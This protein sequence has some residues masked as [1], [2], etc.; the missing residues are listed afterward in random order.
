V[1]HAAVSRD[2]NLRVI[3]CLTFDRRAAPQEIAAGKAA[4]IACRSVLHSVELSGTFD[5]MFEAEIAD[6]AAYNAQLNLCAEPM[7]R[8]V[9]RYE[10]NFVC[11]RFVRREKADRAIWVPHNNG[12]KRIDCAAI[13]KV[14]A[15][16]DYMRVHS[17]R[18]SWML[19]ST[20]G[21]LKERLGCED[22]IQLNRSLIVRCGF[23]GEVVHSGRQWTAVLNDGTRERIAKGGVPAMFEMLNTDST[24]AKRRLSTLEATVEA[25]ATS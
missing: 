8:L 4:I 10:A 17:A 6:M 16:G 3:M 18:Q 21:A 9:S 20:M 13:D 5:F 22:F 15:Q 24:N 12:M 2:S 19:H 25:R 7:A 11:T 1:N 14:A 23:I